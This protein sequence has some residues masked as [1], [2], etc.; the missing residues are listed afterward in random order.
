MDI[1]KNKHVSD[2]FN[3]KLLNHAKQ[4]AAG[5]FK[6]ASKSTILKKAEAACDLIR[7]KIANKNASTA[8]RSNLD[9]AQKTGQKS[10]IPNERY[11][12]PEKR[13]EIVDECC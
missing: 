1:D 11:K 2:K 8:S 10:E 6:T 12:S 3:Q 9:A 7:I 13:P 5:A 4:S